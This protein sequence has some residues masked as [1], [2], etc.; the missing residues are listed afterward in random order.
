MT[1]W[2]NI[3]KAMGWIDADQPAE[4]GYGKRPGADDNCTNIVGPNRGHREAGLVFCSEQH[5]VRDQE[6]ATF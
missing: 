2:G 5:A 3:K 6:E 1:I 4:C